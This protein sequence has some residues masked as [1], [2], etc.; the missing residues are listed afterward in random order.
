MSEPTF[1]TLPPG[2]R[3]LIE[4]G[5]G[6]YYNTAAAG[7]LGAVASTT[8]APML[9]N[10]SDSDVRLKIL[11]IRYG[12]VSGTVILGH[13]AYGLLLTAGA[14]IGTAQPVVSYTAGTPVNAVPGA[15]RVSKIK[16]APLT[17]TLT[18]APTY[19]MPNGLSSG[20]ALAAGPLYKLDDDVSGGLVINP[21]IAF[22][23]YISNAALALTAAVS[24]FAL[25]IPISQTI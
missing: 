22:F 7:V 15:G 14:Q 12:S 8:S 18:A 23:P 11:R 10:P 13:I 1:T 24:V 17:L 25:E 21:G 5:Y 2:I 20:G 19:F 6:F 16:F 9:W 3:D 4:M